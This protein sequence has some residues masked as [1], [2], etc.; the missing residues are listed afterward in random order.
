[1][2]HHNDSYFNGTLLEYFGIILISFLASFFT[3]GLAAPWAFCYRERWV[4]QHTYIEGRQLHFV[5]TALDLWLCLVKWTVFSILTLDL[6]GFV[7]PI[8]F[9][10]WR[11]KNTYVY[12]YWDEY[13]A[14]E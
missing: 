4:A 3:F 2:R 12:G 10:Q 6:Y 9:Q 11:V 5:G 13:Y 8:R 14:T 7:L 1:M